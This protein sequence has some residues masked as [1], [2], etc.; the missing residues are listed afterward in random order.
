[1]SSGMN[2]MTAPGYISEI[3]ELTQREVRHYGLCSRIYLMNLNYYVKV[4]ST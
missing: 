2:V 1:M 4:M 3:W